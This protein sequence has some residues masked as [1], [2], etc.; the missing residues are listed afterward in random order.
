M[1]GRCTCKQ[2]LINKGCGVQNGQY[3]DKK[4]LLE[5]Q[6]ELNVVVRNEA[7]PELNTSSK[8]NK[9]KNN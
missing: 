8:Q 4:V 9:T 3:E 5:T 2:K 6:T 1:T 7:R